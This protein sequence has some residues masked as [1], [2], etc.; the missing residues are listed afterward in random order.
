MEGNEVV[1]NCGA[2]GTKDNDEGGLDIGQRLT[3]SDQELDLMSAT[4]SIASK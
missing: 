3:S 1:N 4:T 2:Q